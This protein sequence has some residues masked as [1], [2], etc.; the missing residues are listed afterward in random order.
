MFLCWQSDRMLILN[1]GMS[2]R[3][4]SARFGGLI[5]P[6]ASIYG[7]FGCFCGREELNCVRACFFSVLVRLR[8]LANA[9]A[10]TYDQ[11]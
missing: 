4:C 1:L 5:V 8:R 9:E 3:K 6:T 11:L 2:R 7:R 10:E